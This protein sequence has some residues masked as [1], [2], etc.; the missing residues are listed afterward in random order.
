MSFCAA[1][2]P[3]ITISGK[4][5]SA[6]VYVAGFDTLDSASYGQIVQLLSVPCMKGSKIAIMPD[7]H[8][9]IG[10]CVGYTQT[11]TDTIVPN[12]VG[13]DIACFTKDTK[14]RLADGRDLSFEELINESDVDHYGYALDK[15]GHVQIAKLDCPRKISHA[16]SLL[17]ITLDNG[18]TIKCTKDHV[19]FKRDLT[20]VGASEL[21]IG[22]SL[23]PLYLKPRCDITDSEFYVSNERLTGDTNHLCV[24]DAVDNKYHYVHWLSDDYNARHGYVSY[25]GKSFVRHHVDFNKFNNNPTN[26]ARLSYVDHWKVHANSMRITNAMGVTG[27]AAAGKKHP[28][29]FSIAGKKRAE[30]TWHGKNADKNRSDWS[31]RMKNR[32]LDNEFAQKQR[33]LSSKRQLLHN[34]QKFTSYNSEEW[35]QNRQKL[36]KIR[37]VLAA[38]DAEHVELTADSYDAYK[39]RFYNYSCYSKVVDLLSKLNFTFDDVRNGK[40]PPNHRIV[41]IEEIPGDD[42]YCLTN[43]E[44]GNFALSAGV[45]VHNC[46]MLVCKISPEYQFNYERLDKLIRLN[47]PSGMNHRKTLHTFAKNVDLSGLV[48]DTDRNKLLYSVGSLGGGNHFIEVDVDEAGDHYIVIHSGSRY[49]G[50]VVCKFHQQRAI[51]RYLRNR[52]A[53]SDETQYPSN[54]AWLEGTDVDDYLNDMKI[55]SEFSYWN[56]KTML[57]EIL[58]GMDIKRRYIMEEFTTLHNYVD[59]DNK[60]IRKGSISLQDGERAIIPMN[61]R[62]GSLIVTGK[63]NAAANFSGPHGAGRV[64]S[65]GDAKAKLSMEDFKAAM[66]GIYSTSVRTSTIDES[67]MAYK[68]VQAILDNIGDLCTVD[69][70]I[71]PE[72]NFKAS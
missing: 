55:C 11:F 72:Y 48:A 38:L 71:K 70:V 8:A 42:V 43:F 37:R 56:R 45:F 33:E 23:Y 61:M 53:T 7:V 58:D 17:A 19:F 47:I 20:E 69:T 41:H 60:I 28:N 39:D 54:L 44:Y 18:E 1:Y 46:G 62:D 50:Q 64:L 13:V 24:Y 21:K 26:I 30:S 49:L 40:V 22:D 25:T 32:W 5:A 35:F 16:D 12:L 3:M 31:Q 15:D 68:P 51:D 14:V 36:G 67:P 6:D 66:E 65:R 27:Y 9:G 52:K 4:Y 10:A 57:Q 34:T 59:V 29:L 63:G 2:M